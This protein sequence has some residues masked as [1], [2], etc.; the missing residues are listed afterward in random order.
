MDLAAFGCTKY[1][2][3]MRT[4][5]FAAAVAAAL[6]TAAM[7]GNDGPFTTNEWTNG[8]YAQPG[9]GPVRIFPDPATDRFNIIFPG[10]TGEAVVSVISSEGRV[11]DQ[12]EVGNTANSRMEYDTG[13]LVNGIYIIRVQQPDGLTLTQRVV[14]DK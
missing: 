7:P 4:V 12:Q 6:S 3:A 10:L 1:R 5:I 8:L 14:V 13:R 2:N 9:E 11:I